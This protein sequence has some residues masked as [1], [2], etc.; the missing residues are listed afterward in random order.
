MTCHSRGHP[1]EF[2]LY[3]H[4]AGTW[5]KGIVSDEYGVPPDACPV[6]IVNQIRTY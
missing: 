3:G 4:D 2:F 1:V 5:S 6:P